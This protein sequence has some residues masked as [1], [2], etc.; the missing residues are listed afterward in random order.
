MHQ[1]PISGSDWLRD[2]NSVVN[3]LIQFSV[4][5]KWPGDPLSVPKKIPWEPL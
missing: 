5:A 1:A 2:L 4:D 3:E